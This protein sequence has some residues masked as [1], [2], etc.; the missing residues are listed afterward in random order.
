MARA[1]RIEEEA[2]S[3]LLSPLLPIFAL[4]T[5]TGMVYTRLRLTVEVWEVVENIRKGRFFKGF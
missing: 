2:G 1:F 5:P 3:L 4:L